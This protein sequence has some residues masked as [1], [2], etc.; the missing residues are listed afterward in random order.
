MRRRQFRHSCDDF[1]VPDE[2]SDAVW[3]IGQG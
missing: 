2:T 1:A 3:L